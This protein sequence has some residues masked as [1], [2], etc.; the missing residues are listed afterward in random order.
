[1]ASTVQIDDAAVTAALAKLQAAGQDLSPIL[2]AIGD[3]IME[4][5]KQR[6]SSATG[7]DGA[8]WRANARSTIEAFIRAKGGFAEKH[9]TKKGYID[10]TVQRWAMA[11][12]P[13]QG[14]SGDLARQFHV[15]VQGN[16]VTVGNSMVYA[17]M[18]QFGGKKSKFPKL[19]GDIPAR[20]FLP[21]T[22]E[23]E[24]DPHER[25]SILAQLN[26]YLAGAVEG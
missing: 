1:M 21:I 26:G 16:A 14:H 9:L 13:L 12:R 25:E 2:Q 17:A 7:P 3:D 6:F 10:K 8:P 4:R 20:P 24:L 22:A 19:W 5:A 11:K 23:G 18:Q 15:A